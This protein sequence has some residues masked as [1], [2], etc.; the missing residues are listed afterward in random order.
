MS[1]LSRTAPSSSA[2]QA[3]PTSS[4]WVQ[5]APVSTAEPSTSTYVAPTSTYVAPTSTYVAPVETT[6][7][8][9]TGGDWKTGGHGKL[10]AKLKEEEKLNPFCLY[11]HLLLPER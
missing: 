8:V 2:E 7:A 4:L 9:S 5:A 10:V 3:E 11:S 6:A 1:P